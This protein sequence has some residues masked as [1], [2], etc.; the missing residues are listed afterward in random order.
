[1]SGLFHMSTALFRFMFLVGIYK[2]DDLFLFPPFCR[3]LAYDV[4]S[5][6]VCVSLFIYAV[7]MFIMFL[8][9]SIELPLCV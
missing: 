6:L 2:Q 8:V 4:K 7:S 9:P 3:L 5:C 1:M